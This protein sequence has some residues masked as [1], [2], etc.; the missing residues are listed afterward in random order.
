G[1][2]VT[3]PGDWVGVS[4]GLGPRVT[5]DGHQ[6]LTIS[7]PQHLRGDTGGLC[8]PYNGDPSD[9]LSRPG[10]DVTLSA[11]AFGNSW[12]VP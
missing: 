4:S 8:G 6:T 2:S 12:K 7:L 1:V 11:A 10:G 9:D 5:W 3:W